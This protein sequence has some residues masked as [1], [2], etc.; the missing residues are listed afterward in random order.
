[1]NKLFAEVYLDENIDVRV[2]KIIRARGFHALTTD[3][4]G[5]KGSNDPDQL[6]FAVEKGF[7]ILTMNRVDFERLAKEYFYTGQHHSGIII[8]ADHSP[9]GIAQRLNDFLDFNTANEVANQIVYI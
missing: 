7:A 1:M 9:Y 5:R 2:A 3:E 4:A 8:V 6:K